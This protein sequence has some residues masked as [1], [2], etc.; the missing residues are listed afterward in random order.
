[1]GAGAELVT[2]LAVLAASVAVVVALAV[3]DGAVVVAGAVEACVV[4]PNRPPAVAGV[5]VVFAPNRLEAV[6]AD[7]AAAVVVAGL[8]NREVCAGADA[9]VDVVV[10]AEEVVANKDGFEAEFAAVVVV[11]PPSPLN[12]PPAAGA[13]V[14]VVPEAAVVVAGLAPNRLPALL[15]AGVGSAGLEAAAPPPKRVGFGAV[16]VLA[17]NRGLEPAVADAGL[18]KRLG[19]AG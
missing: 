5:V 6:E 16:V 15:L 3:V 9:G 14:A 13:V 18:L 1:M 17:P 4:A 11:A 19:D 2:L 8:L 7:G 12:I 10:E